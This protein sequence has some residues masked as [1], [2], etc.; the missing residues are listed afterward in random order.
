[1]CKDVYENVQFK[2]KFKDKD[3]IIKVMK[4]SPSISA[5]TILITKLVTQ[6]PNSQKANKRENHW[7]HWE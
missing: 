2:D 4:I 5:K 6:S 7:V 1:M 3:K